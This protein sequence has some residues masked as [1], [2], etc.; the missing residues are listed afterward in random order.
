MVLGVLLRESLQVLE[1]RFEGYSSTD[2]NQ[3]EILM[4]FHCSSDGMKIFEP[5]IL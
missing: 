2:L 1:G 5:K 4:L 3:M